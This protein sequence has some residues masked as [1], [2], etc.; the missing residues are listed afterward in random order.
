MN[1]LLQIKKFLQGLF[2]KFKNNILNHF[3]FLLFFFIPFFVSAQFNVTGS[4]TQGNSTTTGAQQHPKV[5]FDSLGNYVLVWESFGEDG[6]DYGIFAQRFLPDGSTVGS[7]F[8][9]NTTTTDGQ[10]FPDIAQNKNGNFTVVWMSEN[11]DGDGWGIYLSVYNSAGALV[12]GPLLVNSTTSGYQKFPAVASGG[13]NTV[14]VWE[15]GQNN[16]DIFAKIFNS[17]GN[18]TVSDFLVNDSINGHQGMPAVAVD[19]SGSFVIAWQD[20]ADD[21]DGNGVF[22]QRFD[23]TGAALG[24]NFQVNT[25]NAG[26]QQ[27]PQIAK[28]LNGKFLISWSSFGQ[29]SDDYGVYSRIYDSA[30]TAITGEISVN[31]ETTGAQ[32]NESVVALFDG[33]FG[34]S[35]SSYGQDGSFTGVYLQ[36]IN[37]DGTKQG[38]E[39]LVNTNTTDFQHFSDLAVSKDILIATWQDGQISGS[40]TN[41]GSS[42]GIFFQLFDIVIPPTAICRDITVYLNGA[43]NAIITA[44]YIDNGSFD[45]DGLIVSKSVD[46]TNFNCS[47]IGDNPV[48]LTV[49]DNEA[50]VDT[51]VATVTILDSVPPVASCQNI[52]VFLDGAGNAAIS[53]G[54][55]DGGSSDNCSL[56]TLSLNISSF[57]CADIG[58]NTVTL[59]VPDS[60]GNSTSCNA[61][62]TVSDTV[63]P[64][65]SCQNITVFLDGAG[66][67]AITPWDIDAG[68]S[69]N[70][71]LGTLSLN[72][73]SFTCAD[74]GA[75]TVTLTVPDSN[76]N[77]ASCT[78]TVTVNDTVSPVASCQNITVYL[79]GAGNA[80]ITPSDINNGSSDNCSLGTLSLNKSSF[81]CANIGANTVTLTVPDSNGNSASCT[82]TVTVSDT[83]PPVASCQN[84]TV[85]LDGAGNAA[86]S[87]GDIDGG[88]SDNCSLG[89]LSLNISSFTCADIGANTVTLTVPDS[90]GNSAS[91][92]A[93][94]SVADTISPQISCPGDQTVSTGVNCVFIVPD[95]RSL[96]SATDNCASP[97]IIS[98]SPDSGSIVNEGLT[99]ITLTATDGI[100]TSTCSFNLIVNGPEANFN[101]DETTVCYNKQVWFIDLSN[102]ATAWEC[103]FGDGN[104]ADEQNPT[105][106]YSQLGTYNVTLI[107]TDSFGCKDT[108]VKTDYIDVQPPIASFSAT[109]LDGCTIPH[110]VFFTDQSQLPDTWSWNFGDGNT[111]TAQN[112]IHTYTSA[113]EYTV[114][115]LVTDTITGCTDTSTAMISV[116]FPVADFT[117]SPVFGCGPLTVNFT[118]LSN[119][120]GGSSI[121]SWSWNFGDGN[122]SNL[123]NPEHTYLKPGVYSVTLTISTNSGCTDIETKTNLVQV[124]GPDVNF[125]ADTVFAECAPFDVSFTDSTIFTAP[126]V[127]WAWDFGDGNNSN[128]QNPVHTYL[129]NGNFNISLTVTDLDGCSRTFIR[130]DYITVQVASVPEITCPANVTIECDESTDPFNTSEAIVTD[131]CDPNPTLIYLDSIV[132]GACINEFTIYR[133][134]KATNILGKSDSCVQIITVQDTTPP[135]LV[136]P[137]DLTLECPADTLPSITGFPYVSDNCDTLVNV[138]YINESFKGFGVND[139]IRRTWIAIDNCGN[140]SSCIQTILIVDTTPP[141]AICDT[142]ITIYLDELGMTHIDSSDIDNGSYDLCG[143]LTMQLNVTSFNCSDVGDNLVTLTVTDENDNFSECISHVTVKDTIPPVVICNP[144][145]LVLY[146]NGE[147]VLNHF[148]IIEIATG[149]FDNCTDFEDLQLDVFPKSFECVHVRGPVTIKVTATDASGNTSICHTTVTVYDKTPP[150]ALCQNLKI[151]LD[152]NGEAYI[153]PG[154]VNAGKDRASIPEWARTYNGIEK[155]SYDACGIEIIELDKYR[156]DCTNLGENVVVLTTVDPSGNSSTCSS[157]VTVT[158][159]MFPAI[160]EVEDITIEVAPGICE[161]GIDYPDFV[162]SDN[163]ETFLVQLSG[164]GANGFFPLGTTIEKWQVNDLNGNTAEVSFSV[165]VIA[166]NSLPTINSI[167][168][169]VVEEDTYGILVPLSGIGAGNDCLQQTLK[170]EIENTN[171]TLIGSAMLDYTEGEATGEISIEFVPDMSGEAEFTI[172]IIDSENDS[173]SETF[174][175]F[176]TP[177]NDAPVLLKPIEDQHVNASYSLNI[178]I[179]EKTGGMFTD[180]DD[181]I[182]VFKVKKEG[183]DILPEWVNFNEGVL[184]FAPM[185]ADTG[186]INLVVSASD[187]AGLTDSD[188]FQVCVLGYPV[189]INELDEG[190]FE[191]KMYPNPTQGP[192]NIDFTVTQLEKIIIRVMNISGQE[193]FRKEYKYTDAIR[194]NLRDNVSG[195]YMV[196]IETENNRYVRKLIVDRK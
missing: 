195:M 130:S 33:R 124:T 2:G 106:Q 75:N 109:P 176:V 161:T 43:G 7:Q 107:V 166:S 182:L 194:F 30:G 39:H 14:V 119:S 157:V 147:Y 68:S 154:Q 131:D 17:N 132:T 175:V 92:N 184:S 173:I 102:N 42:Y 114:T 122:T 76:G 11:E 151:E 179:D 113:G 3:F 21:G 38:L 146:E 183:T 55:I 36:A 126:I 144:K 77:S 158:D 5:A 136:C 162:I 78:A 177:V 16:G 26:N 51:C 105:Y 28:S 153:F 171:P 168:D 96:A 69:D 56:G 196:I 62:V 121:S 54:D 41:D 159:N 108:L 31:S 111:S 1:D 193:V 24:N 79:D 156:F 65:A 127:S 190:D 89:T 48:S 13:S 188:T 80:V 125:G 93:T 59:T 52:T 40:T 95:Y 22:A 10:R 91:C 4:E 45:E 187:A 178:E 71:S 185:I 6:D 181:D 143:N 35:W 142:S 84:I 192:V 99:V 85:F 174:K 20:D 110:T 145:A 81:T 103:D 116:V 98:Q 138:T 53:S 34:V 87:S 104:I 172:L 191:L 67:A 64:V 101:A 61:T 25:T 47:D 94:I 163:C 66:N 58:A 128:L 141:V 73:S 12:N 86:I 169:I 148:D 60:N 82:A 46:I 134:W 165:T 90:N 160:A 149:T 44:D 19:S 133:K 123:Q 117:A 83:V 57:T 32:E 72:K 8:Q 139:T 49:T 15:D 18:A 27:A 112:P 9:V 186:C 50:N 63:S 137:A 135:L 118:D 152:E 164:K 37:P 155:G 140:K 23:N 180:V 74:A 129:T 120:F 100:N 97:V 70:C 29:D 115:L 167:N 88:S 170:I 189:S 150:V